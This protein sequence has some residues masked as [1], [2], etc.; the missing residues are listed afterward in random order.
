MK[1]SIKLSL[2]TLLAVALNMLLDSHFLAELETDT[3]YV[4][5][6]NKRCVITVVA[7]L[8]VGL[9]TLDTIMVTIMDMVHTGVDVVAMEDIITATTVGDETD[10]NP[11]K[12]KKKEKLRQ[13]QLTVSASN[14]HWNESVHNK[15]DSLVHNISKKRK[16][17]T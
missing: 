9:D 17:I 13:L 16:K 11:A 2:L 7:T 10:N 14:K 3:Y 8:I 1:I 12:I 15:E 5:F 4:F 6:Q